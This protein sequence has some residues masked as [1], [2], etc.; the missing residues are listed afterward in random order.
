MIL[1]EE[2]FATYV[3]T[4]TVKGTPDADSGLAEP[5]TDK[6]FNADVDLQPDGRIIPGVDQ[7]EGR[8]QGYTYQLTIQPG[9][10]L[11]T[12]LHGPL[13]VVSSYVWSDE[14]P[15]HAQLSLEEL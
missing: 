9:D 12:T 5:G 3:V 15:Y 8:Y 1:Q 4:R 14:E 11:I 2:R 7:Q 10:Q 6:T 13:R